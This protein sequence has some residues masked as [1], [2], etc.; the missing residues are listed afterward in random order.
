MK[1]NSTV[2]LTF[3]LLLMMIG[4]GSVSAWFGYT[5][6]SESLEGVT[7][8]NSNPTKKL[9]R[10][11]GEKQQTE[12]VFVKEKD[13]IVKNYDHI[14]GKKKPTPPPKEET[15]A[16]NPPENKENQEDSAN[17]E[18]DS[19]I[20][21]PSDA[22]LLASPVQTK[23]K[24]VTLEV[25]N[26]QQSDGAILLNVSLQNDGRTAVRFLYSFLDV[27]DDKGSLLSAITDG[28]PGELPA[29][30]EPYSGTIRIPTALLL[31][32]KTI[33]LSLTD[34]PDQKLQLKLGD[35]PVS[36]PEPKPETPPTE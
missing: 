18:N 13:V 29:N 3:I 5:M 11:Q 12:L 1:I 31:E 36:A 21:T 28:L 10:K 17:K 25:R 23:D 6:G 4:A 22:P 26:I 9:T 27:R 24:D 33:S 15:P 8:P 7:E 19:F 20:S 14:K 16:P 35:L 30:G 32:A 34:Y 2:I